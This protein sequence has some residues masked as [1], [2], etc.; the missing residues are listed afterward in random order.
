MTVRSNIAARIRVQVT[1]LREVEGAADLHG[2]LAGR[3]NAPAAYVFRLRTR[4]GANQLDNAVSQNVS[5]S[6][7][8]VVVTKNLRDERGG[9]SSD[10]NEVLCDQISTALLGWE[11]DVDADTLEYEGGQLVSMKDGYFYWQE[12]YKTARLRRAV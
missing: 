6:Y 11:P 5:E 3:V 8:V 2:V 12:V 9:D 4:A 7:A 1:G 10:A